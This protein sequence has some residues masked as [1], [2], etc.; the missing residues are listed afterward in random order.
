[1][2]FME[3]K[4]LGKTATP[5]LKKSDRVKRLEDRGKF[6]EKSLKQLLQKIIDE[7]K[8]IERGNLF[9][10]V[11][12][13]TESGEKEEIVNKVLFILQE[14]GK[15]K[16]LE[17][18]IADEKSDVVVMKTVQKDDLTRFFSQS[19]MEDKGGCEG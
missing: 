14:Q 19:K 10:K 3:E 4:T 16:I 9:K 7:D 13:E 5:T 18:K 6:S 15:I 1:M 11:K 12:I 17:P 8:V 2:Y